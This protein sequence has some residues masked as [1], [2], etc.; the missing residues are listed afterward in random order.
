MPSPTTHYV[1]YGVG[2]DPDYGSHRGYGDDSWIEEMDGLF[3]ATTSLF[4]AGQ[5]QLAVDCVHRALPYLPAWRG[6][7]PLHAP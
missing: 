3:A 4:R 7:L 1:E 6:R 2:Y 5:F